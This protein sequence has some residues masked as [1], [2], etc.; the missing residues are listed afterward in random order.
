MMP[1]CDRGVRRRDISARTLGVVTVAVAYVMGA[2]MA[3]AVGE[4][5]A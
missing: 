3:G 4:S 5:A 1:I 2:G